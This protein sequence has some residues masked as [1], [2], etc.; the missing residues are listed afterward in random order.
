VNVG[1]CDYGIDTDHEDLAG[2]MHPTLWF[3]PNEGDEEW[4]TW[5]HG[6]ATA[7]I[8]GAVGNNDIGISGV[9]T[10]KGGRILVPMRPNETTGD[11]FIASY[12]IDALEWSTADTIFPEVPIVNL[13][14]AL[15]WKPPFPPIAD[16]TLFGLRDACRNVYRKGIFLNVAAVNY[17]NQ[18]RFIYPAQYVDYSYAVTAINCDGSRP[19]EYWTGQ[20]IDATA[21]GGDVTGGDHGYLKTTYGDHPAYN[22]FGEDGAAYFGG[23]SGAAP[24]VA[25]IAALLWSKEPSLTNE[26]I[27]NVLNVTASHLGDAEDYGHGLVR[28]DTALMLVSEP[29]EVVHDGTMASRI[30]SVATRTLDF[31]NIPCI[32]ESWNAPETFTV[33]VYEMVG[34]ASFSDSAL[35]V[36]PRGRQSHGLRNIVDDYDGFFY[37]NWAKVV[38]GTIS[39]A[40]CS[41]RAYTYK[42]Y[43]EGEFQGWYPANGMGYSSCPGTF[44]PTFAYTYVIDAGSSFAS[45]ESRVELLSGGPNPF[46]PR[47]N[48]LVKADPQKRVV[49]EVFGAS[50][51]RLRVLEPTEAAESEGLR[52]IW[53]G[54]DS[55]G[56]D[57][58]SGV[59]FLRVRAGEEVLTRKLQVVR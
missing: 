56:R 24:H 20:H 54:K 57:V 31:M 7:G 17:W 5:P 47:F 52:Y 26:D 35:A 15:T 59:Y 1:I 18:D 40:G 4:P 34:Y 11:G 3:G 58:S 9:A 25:G 55:S 27:A 45:Q 21:P 14:Y 30:D 13:S 48:F 19:N 16:T 39:V 44:N 46:N 36:W 43:K 50:G 10:P 53:D 8:V 38:E 33:H 51:R 41:L 6:S 49:A 22:Y 28:A 29:N 23:T 32:S 2:A 37:D 42:F 12:V